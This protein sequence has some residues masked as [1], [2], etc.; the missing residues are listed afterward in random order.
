MIQEKYPF[1][2]VIALGTVIMVKEKEK[3]KI[4]AIKVQRSVR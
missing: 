4:E 1:L 3:T 2:L